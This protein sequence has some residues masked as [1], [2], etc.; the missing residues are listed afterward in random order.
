L[1]YAKKIQQNEKKLMKYTKKFKITPNLS[2]E[3]QVMWDGLGK[4]T[5]KTNSPNAS[6]GYRGS[7]PSPSARRRHS[8]KRLAS[9]SARVRHSGKRLASPSAKERHSGKSVFK[10]SPFSHII[11]LFASASL[12]RVLHSGK[13]AFPECLSSPSAFLPRVLDIWHSGKP[14]AL[15]EFPFSRSISLSRRGTTL[16]GDD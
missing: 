15:G 11:F 10:I 7:D 8:G 5:K 13:I 2:K 3:F 4:K 14:E 6:S 12:P 9:P 16:A 1:K